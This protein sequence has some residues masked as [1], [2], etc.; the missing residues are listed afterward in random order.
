MGGNHLHFSQREGE[1]EWYCDAW[2]TANGL[3]RFCH[4]E[5][6]RC[7]R[8]QIAKDGLKAMLDARKVEWGDT[9]A[10]PVYG[11]A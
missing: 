10:V 5:G 2:F 9:P 3:P 8:K 1:T 6:S 4:G 11:V 7:C